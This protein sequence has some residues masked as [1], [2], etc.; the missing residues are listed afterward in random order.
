MIEPEFTLP[1]SGDTGPTW[2]ARPVSFAR[3]YAMCS[4]LP[5][6]SSGRPCCWRT[7][8]DRLSP[9]ILCGISVASST[10]RSVWIPCLRWG[11]SLLDP[12]AAC[13]CSGALGQRLVLHAIHGYGLPAP[14][15]YTD[16]IGRWWNASAEGDKTAAIEKL[17]PVFRGMRPMLDEQLDF[18]IH[19]WFRLDGELN[20][21]SEYGYLA[22]D[23]VARQVAAW[24][25]GVS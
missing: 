20:T 18:R 10:I 11:S 3:C 6:S 8:W 2:T 4:C 19:N 23:D 7:A 14:E 12:S 16:N 25:R 22:N 24:L 1:I 17:A 9:G 5:S 15:C 13:G 21:H